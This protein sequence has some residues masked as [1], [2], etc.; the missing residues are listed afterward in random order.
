MSNTPRTDRYELHYIENGNVSKLINLARELERELADMTKQR[1]ALAEAIKSAGITKQRNALAKAI[2]SAGITK[3]RNA[4]AEA[5]KSA[6]MIYI[7]NSGG[8]YQAGWRDAVSWINQQA[9]VFV[10]GGSHG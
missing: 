3:Q 9:L 10:K 1:D 5:I 4:L 6:G 8:A 2:K 7:P